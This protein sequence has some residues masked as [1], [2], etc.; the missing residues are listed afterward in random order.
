MLPFLVILVACGSPA[1][2]P[3]EAPADAPAEAPEPVAEVDAEAPP[4]GR[5]GG[6]PILPKPLVIGAIATTAV[7]EGLAPHRPAIDDCWKAEQATHPE[8]AGKVLVKFKIA[9]DGKV[10]D[11][12]TRSTSLRHPPTEACLNERIA[13]IQFAP[14]Q[15]G[16]YAI[17]QVPFVFPPP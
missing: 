4:P 12:T 10:V 8:L 17:V 16:S 9:G 6:E 1:V 15:G 3:A 11:P 13:A 2:E 14:L 5:I 7:E